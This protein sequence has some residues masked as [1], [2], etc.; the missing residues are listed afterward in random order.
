MKINDIIQITQK[1]HPG[2]L[3]NTNWG[4]LGLFYNPEEKL[5][6]G[7]YL[8]TFKEKDG[9]HDSA[10]K[11]DRGGLYRLNLGISKETFIKIFGTI[12][13]RPRAGEVITMD[14]EFDFT[15]IDTI[16]PHPVYGWMS[17]ISVINPSQK[18]FE[19]LKPLIAEGYKL[20][21]EKYKR[22]KL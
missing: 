13:K 16:M 4:E 5:K 19:M 18:T 20:A 9:E 1:N 6:I 8:M 14:I 15:K 12:P 2:L 22:K 17:W 7:I 3:K 21:V 11:L 10:S